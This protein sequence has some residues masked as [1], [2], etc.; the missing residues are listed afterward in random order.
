MPSNGPRVGVFRV[1]GHCLEKKAC[2]SPSRLSD[3]QNSSSEQHVQY[4]DV[5]LYT[6]KNDFRWQ[7]EPEREHE[8]ERCCSQIYQQAEPISSSSCR[9]PSASRCWIAVFNVTSPLLSSPLPSPPL[10]S[11]IECNIPPRKQKLP[12]SIRTSSSNWKSV[13][14]TGHP[15]VLVRCV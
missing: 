9:I 11:T 3:I 13:I 7:H 14:S 2:V 12:F 15:L 4:K 1:Y 8:R 10:L 5:S 6:G